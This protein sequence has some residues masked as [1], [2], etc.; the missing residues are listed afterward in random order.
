MEEPVL[1]IMGR[2]ALQIWAFVA[3]ITD[4]FILG[5]GVLLAEE[6][7]VNLM[8]HVLRLGEEDVSLWHPEADQLAR[9][10]RVVTL[11]CEDPMEVTNGL[12]DSLKTSYQQGL[13]IARTSIQ[14][15]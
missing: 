8:G 13:H 6:W 9:C 5:L 4:E 2:R 10:E 12:L 15:Q 11:Q 1:L 3:R 7:T 14:A